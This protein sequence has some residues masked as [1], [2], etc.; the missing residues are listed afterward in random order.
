MR[1]M[2]CTN[3][4]VASLLHVRHQTKLVMS[5][6]PRKPPPKLEK[7]RHYFVWKSSSK[8]K[9]LNPTFQRWKWT[10]EGNGVLRA[11]PFLYWFCSGRRM[12]LAKPLAPL[13]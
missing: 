12:A 3:E 2:I 6:S 7:E 9:G 5:E 10:G 1:H 13:S 11:V 8:Q 4:S